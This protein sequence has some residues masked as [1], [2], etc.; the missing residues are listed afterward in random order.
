MATGCALA[1]E[2]A[3]APPAPPAMKAPDSA[4]PQIADPKD[5]TVLEKFLEHA[6]A[7]AAATTVEHCR[8]IETPETFC[9][10]DLKNLDMSLTA[11]RLT[12]DAAH[13]KNFVQAFENLRSI[14]AKGDDGFLG[15]RGK[16]IEMLRDPAKPDVV[17]D[18]IQTSFRAIGVVSRF[19]EI[20]RADA[21]LTKEYG[22]LCDT[23]VDLMENHLLKKWD[24][25][26]RFIDLG[27]RGA[28]Y[29]WNAAYTPMKANLT[30][31]HE[32][33]ANMIEGL[34]NLYRAT[35]KTEH[36]VRAV[37]LGTWLRHCLTLT[38]GRY[39]WSYWD[40]AGQWDVSPADPAKWKHWVGR[41][42]QGQ[43]HAATVGSALLLYHHGVVF[44]RQDVD[45]FLKTQMTVC[46]NGSLDDPK[47]F[48]VDGAEVKAG[49]QMLAP[50]LAPFHEKI[51]EY[52]YAGKRQD[53][54]VE[55]SGNAWHGGVVA[56]E[57]LSGKYL[58]LP[59]A[60]AGHLLYGAAGEKFKATPEGQA[61][62]KAL[63][64][65]VT[66]GSYKTPPTPAVMG[67]VP[68]EPTK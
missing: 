18:E 32:K 42:P 14:L 58:E 64:F 61:L 62:L 55:K 8:K 28:I 6:K 5:K 43:W 11:Y 65:D 19:V 34:L 57:Y 13:V 22:S 35:G 24:A 25:R 2:P 30:L 63:V 48:N 67:T 68:P 17:I 21:A 54:R 45:R 16:P 33:Q 20:V 37:K 31:A 1:A 53:E 52:L 56:N 9:W 59:V 15:W 27:S 7:T 12:G 41:E 3:A 49:Q 44:N 36:M 10:V 40:P 29:R 46:W 60:K 39:T 66:E 38:D 51:A 23:Y 47:F 4:R 50:S 26:G